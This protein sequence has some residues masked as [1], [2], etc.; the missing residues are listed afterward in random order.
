VLFRSIFRVDKV[1][2]RGHRI[3]FLRKSSDGQSTRV[4]KFYKSILGNKDRIIGIVYQGT[5]LL[6]RLPQRC[7]CPFS[8]GNIPDRTNRSG[9]LQTCENVRLQISVWSPG[10][11]SA[12]CLAL[13]SLLTAVYDDAVLTVAGYHHIQTTRA[14]DNLVADPEGGW[15]YAVEYEVSIPE[16]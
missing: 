14:S 10:F 15:Q 5:I 13:Y 16:V 4:W 12:D 7:L 2:E 8:L 6:F 9:G 11:D 3:V 1:E